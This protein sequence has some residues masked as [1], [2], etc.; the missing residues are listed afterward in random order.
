MSGPENKIITKYQGDFIKV[1]GYCYQFAG[2]TSDKVDTVSVDGD[3]N[4][5]DNCNKSKVSMTQC[6]TEVKVIADNEFLIGG[7]SFPIMVKGLNFEA[8]ELTVGRV[9][10]HG[11][12]IATFD[13]CTGDGSRH[14]KLFSI[15]AGNIL[16]MK[17]FKI[18]KYEIRLQSM[19]SEGLIFEKSVGIL[20]SEKV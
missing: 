6:T 1:D 3:F 4:S 8:E 15:E 9:S 12:S 16:K 18:G 17:P 19:S 7:Y 14:N 20:L 11:D 13:I 10:M 2:Y 5:F